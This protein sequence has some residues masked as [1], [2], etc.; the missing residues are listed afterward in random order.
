MA[1]KRRSWKT[2]FWEPVEC[3]VKNCWCRGVKA[4]T[5]TTIIPCGDM[6]KSMVNF[7]IREHNELLRRR[8]NDD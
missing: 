1:K 8:K 4:E 3:D 6:H 5:G 2:T 7:I